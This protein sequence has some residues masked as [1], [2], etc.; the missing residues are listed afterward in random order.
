MQHTLLI[1]KIESLIRIKKRL[2][3]W[4]EE[5]YKDWEEKKLT[6]AEKD[7]VYNYTASGASVLNDYLIA[8][9]GNLVEKQEDLPPGTDY[10]L[11]DA[12]KIQ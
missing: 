11:A 4:G 7:I 3:K 9:K 5:K 6:K 2:K 10:K 12:Q 1:Q 8:T